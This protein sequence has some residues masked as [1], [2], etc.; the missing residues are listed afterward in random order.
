VTTPEELVDYVVADALAPPAEW[1][2]AFDFVLGSYTLQV[3]PPGLRA[4]AAG[5]ARTI[6]A[7]ARA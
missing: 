3:L 6:A 1:A 2:G 7:G 5:C 4:A